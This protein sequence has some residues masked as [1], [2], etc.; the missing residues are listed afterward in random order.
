MSAYELSV[1]E[2]ADQIQPIGE[3]R[4]DIRNGRLI[5]EIR[6]GTGRQPRKAKDICIEFDPPSVAREKRERRND[7][8]RGGNIAKQLAARLGLKWMKRDA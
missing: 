1:F 3:L 7:D 4:E 8:R 6:A 5:N 2:I